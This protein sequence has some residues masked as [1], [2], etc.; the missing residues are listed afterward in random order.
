MIGA[1][2]IEA[3][4]MAMLVNMPFSDFNGEIVHVVK[5]IGNVAQYLDVWEISEYKR[6]ACESVLMR[7]DDP[8]IQKQIES[9][10]VYVLTD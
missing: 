4:C 1:K 10:K 2:P 8:D 7:I 6:G 5:Y 3:G 9:E